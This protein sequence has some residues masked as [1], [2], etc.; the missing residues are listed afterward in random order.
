MNDNIKLYQ[1]DCL[2]IM[3]VNIPDKSVD[4]ILC[5]LPYGTTQ[6]SWDNI[7]PFEPLWE[8]YKRV[9]KDN[10]AIV[11]FGSEP[12]TS[13]LVCSQIDLFRYDLVWNKQRGSDFLN[14]NRKPLDCHEN[15]LVFY[16]KSP[17]YNKQC[18]YSTPYK[19]ING[20]RKYS[21][22][23]HK[24]H[25]VDSESLDGKRNPLSILSFARDESMLH[26]TQKPVAL[27]DWLIRTYTNENETVLD[28]CMGSG[29]TGVACI[30]TNR[31]FIG[32]EKDEK[33]FDVSKKR[34]EE[35]TFFL[36]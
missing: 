34:I 23:Y 8:Q 5:D 9:I 2:D 33:Y 12:F 3:G 27:L 31:K 29:S 6:C 18:W 32:I 17:T 1:G 24:V 35:Q 7:I 28:N 11:L 30:G 14:A 15:I 21:T 19:K 13:K 22:V 4:M 25:E 26:H 10:G 20:D 16:K 36:S